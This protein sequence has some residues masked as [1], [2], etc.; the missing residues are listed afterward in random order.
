MLAQPKAHAQNLNEAPKPLAEATKKE[1]DKALCRKRRSVRRTKVTRDPKTGKI[2]RRSYSKKIQ[3]PV[4]SPPEAAARIKAFCTKY[5]AKSCSEARIKVRKLKAQLRDAQGRLA[6]GRELLR[7]PDKIE[8]ELATTTAWIA[9]NCP[10]RDAFI[11]GLLEDYTVHIFQTSTRLGSTPPPGCTHFLSSG[12]IECRNGRVVEVL[13]RFYTC[14]GVS[15][16]YVTEE[17]KVGERCPKGTAET[18][19]PYLGHPKYIPVAPIPPAK[20]IPPKKAPVKKVLP[21]APDGPRTELKTSYRLPVESGLGERS[22]VQY[23]GPTPERSSVMFSVVAMTHFRS[24]DVLAL[25]V[26][27]SELSGFAIALDQLHP[28]SELFEVEPPQLGTLEEG[29]NALIYR[30]NASTL[31]SDEFWYM[32]QDAEGTLKTWNV[33]VVPDVGDDF[34]GFELDWTSLFEDEQA[35]SE[36]ETVQETGPAPVL[37]TPYLA[38][39]KQPIPATAPLGF[40]PVSSPL[41]PSRFLAE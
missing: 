23:V 12:G 18:P 41:L 5:L 14:P 11:E 37:L 24:G 16:T 26:E 9:E 34:V 2:R 19:H 38:P 7:D 4:I 10:D 15:Q 3:P 20:K 22:E 29:D 35:E 30:P 1:I 28:G 6:D 21:K 40:D 27:G 33:L 25:A 31:E 13:Y 17:I 39:D 32:T 36:P 8:E